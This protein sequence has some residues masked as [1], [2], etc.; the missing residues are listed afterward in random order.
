MLWAENAAENAVTRVLGAIV[1]SAVIIA[2]FAAEI[3]MLFLGMVVFIMWL[4]LPLFLFAVFF[5]AYGF[6]SGDIFSGIFWLFIFFASLWILSFS[7]RL[8]VESQKNYF[9]MPLVRLARE[10][11]FTR[12]WERIGGIPGSS[13]H[14]SLDNPELLARF[15]AARQISEQEFQKI[16]EWEKN[17]A[18]EREN[19]RKFWNQER[20]NQL[21]PI[22]REWT[23][24]FTVNLDK[25]SSDLS[26]GDW[27]EYSQSKLVG[28]D[29]E[30]AM[31]E[32]VLTRPSQN[33]VLIVAEAG[34]G[35][36][37][38]FHALAERVRSMKGNSALANKRILDLNLNEVLSSAADPG[39][40]DQNLREIFFEAAYAGNIIL[41]VSDIDQFLRSN[42][43]SPKENIAPVLLEF[44]NY[45]TFQIIGLTTPEKFHQDLEKNA[46]IMKFFEKVQMGESS[47][48]DALVI[49]LYKLKNAEKGRVIFTYAALKEIVKEAERYFTDAPFPEKALDLAEEVLLYWSQ[50]SAEKY[51]TP[52]VVDE[53]VSQKV[54]VPIGD[55]GETEKDKLIHLE[56]ILHERVVGQDFAISQ[57]AETMRRA[58]TGMANLGKPIGSF[59]FL[60]PTGVGK[61]ESAK[62]LAEAY[63]GDE[64]RMIRLDMSE[65]QQANSIDRLIGSLESGRPGILEDKVK[66]NPYALLLLDEIEKAHPD[67]L[68]LFLQILDEGWVTDVYGKK[69]NFKNQIII[70]T[71]NAGSEIIK[72]AVEAGTSPQEIQKKI[73]DY[74]IKN[75]I[76]RAELLNRFE[77]VIFF[78]PLN[79]KEILKVTE[80]LLS[81]Y[82]ERL[83]QE[84][85]I[86]LQFEPEVA[87]AV[88]AAGF[89]P[90]FGAR[91]ISRYVED[92]VGD[93][94]VKK[95]ISGEIKENDN[96]TFS[97]KDIG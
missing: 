90:V 54:K 97:A 63:F 48:E 67:I 20:L 79:K 37:S 13:T 85:N 45:P 57:I 83:F 26:R 74:V 66:E 29:Q 70:A 71:S 41:A 77:G 49:L 44:L 24:A 10:P 28:H 73:T 65:Y 46:G 94:I 95:I 22:G 3:L 1:R 7:R 51:I 87:T 59:L 35:K 82:A 36:H 43:S 47:P 4:L 8:Y 9:E 88:A 93:R 40:L 56:E 18:M 60:G 30:L 62:T 96:L 58:R 50:N 52:Q 27:S 61:T 5:S 68:N 25:Y 17:N 38:L 76:F 39:L 53:V 64:K 91:A 12:V 14:S 33:N 86:H 42:P 21:L 19:S 75:G 34:V 69:I 80:K 84:K 81:K 2:G 89:D 16:V 32:L 15:L 23:Y 78:H 31:L 72:E 92:K 55:I 11:W 6:S